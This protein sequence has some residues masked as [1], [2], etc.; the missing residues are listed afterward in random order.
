M[1]IFDH[2]CEFYILLFIVNHLQLNLKYFTNP[3]IMEEC[4][5]KIVRDPRKSLKEIKFK[6]SKNLFVTW[7]NENA[8]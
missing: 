2:F 1:H 7:I 6:N 3:R 4:N 8:R 5:V